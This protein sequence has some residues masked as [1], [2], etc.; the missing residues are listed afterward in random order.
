MAVTVTAPG[1]AAAG[2]AAA[3]TGA[4]QGRSPWRLAWDRLCRDPEAGLA[5]LAS[6]LDAPVAD[7]AALA[8]LVEAPKTLGRLIAELLTTAGRCFPGARIIPLGS[9]MQPRA[10]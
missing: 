4:V 3:P 10:N 1:Q 5:E 2:A 7:A 6:F 9:G 8:G